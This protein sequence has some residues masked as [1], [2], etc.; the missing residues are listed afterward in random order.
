MNYSESNNRKIG[1][2]A[3]VVIA[4]AAMM[5]PGAS[6]TSTAFAHKS[7]SISGSGNVQQSISQSN[8]VSASNSGT[9]G[10]ASA[11]H[12]T[13]TNNAA[14]IASVDIHNGGS[15]DKKSGHHHKG[16][17]IKGSGNVVQS[18]DQSN[19][20]SASNSGSF[21]SASADFNT[22]ANNAAN[23]AGVDIHNHG[24]GKIKD[25]GNVLQ[26]IGQSNSITATNTGTGGSASAD[27]NT[28]TNNAANIA[29]VD[30]SNHGGYHG[31]KIKDSGNV[32]QLIGQDNSITATN[33]PA[34]TLLA[35]LVGESIPP[36]SSASA[37]FNTQTNNAANIAS[38][39]IH[40][41]GGGTIKD[42]GNVAQLIAQANSINATNTGSFGSASA[43]FNTQSNNATNFADISISNH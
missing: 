3:A 2:V 14:N 10:S 20:I 36:C 38:V 29:S 35:C 34:P 26:A 39:D 42:S 19:S 9:G 28:Q 31:G 6:L 32:A 41:H 24:G 4:I 18:I 1:I 15:H 5:I 12:N 27:F 21:G 40:N 13:Q 37:D 17:S 30:I 7:D 43:D 25:S 11:D 33:S 8:S 22:Q 23:I 16:G